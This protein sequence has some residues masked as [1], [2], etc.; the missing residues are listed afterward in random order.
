[1]V[2]NL[3]AFDFLKSPA[4]PRSI[5]ACGA[6]TET[7]KAAYDLISETL[8]KYP[9][10]AVIYTHSHV[11]HFAGARWLNFARGE[12]YFTRCRF[13]ISCAVRPPP[14]GRCRE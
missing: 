10:V 14:P 9:I 3:A 8:G 12:T 13:W 1:M 6:T 11:D 5:P 7:A 2:W 4:L